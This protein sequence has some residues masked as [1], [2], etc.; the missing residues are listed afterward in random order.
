MSDL[1]GTTRT[2]ALIV[3]DVQKDFCEEGSLAVEGGLQVS[4]DLHD[5]LNNGGKVYYARIVATKDWHNRM[6]DNG[7]HFHESPDYADTWPGHC[8]A[9]TTGAE[10]ANGL[11]ALQFDETFHK[12]WNEPAYSGFQGE[13]VAHHQSL[14]TYLRTYG[15]DEVDVCGIATDYCVKATVLDALD[16]GYKVRVLSRLTVA[17]GNKADALAELESAGATIV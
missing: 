11:N 10:F 2:R 16:K 1:R 13:G 6:G 3:V 14:D 12:G 4:H 15:V 17:V 5:L 8:V 9:G 7:G